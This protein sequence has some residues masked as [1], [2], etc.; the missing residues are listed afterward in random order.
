M[1]AWHGHR[2]QHHQLYNSTWGKV[3]IACEHSCGAED[4]R[5]R[6]W[7]Q[8]IKHLA[9]SILLSTRCSGSVPL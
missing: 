5:A 1:D 8:E 9:P 3:V 4:T 7:R 6:F 2:L